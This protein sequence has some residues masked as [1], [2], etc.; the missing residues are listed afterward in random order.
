VSLCKVI[1]IILTIL[2]KV[3]V[4]ESAGDVIWVGKRG[5]T[6]HIHVKEA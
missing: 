3:T 2:G 1:K 5:V 4:L 6:L